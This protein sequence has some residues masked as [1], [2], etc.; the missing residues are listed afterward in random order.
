MFYSNQNQEEMVQARKHHGQE[1]Y[2]E[3][4][5]DIA[6]TATSYGDESLNETI[7]SITKKGE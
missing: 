6:R 7:N 2:D 5:K 1:Y 3:T 4:I